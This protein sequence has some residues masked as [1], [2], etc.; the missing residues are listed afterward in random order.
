[1][2]KGRRSRNRF[3][4]R[5]MG[6]GDAATLRRDPAGRVVAPGKPVYR[7]S[8]VR[9]SIGGVDVTGWMADDDAITLPKLPDDQQ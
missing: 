6:M 2:S 9:V 3:V 5:A 8:D 4:K 1:M 7:F